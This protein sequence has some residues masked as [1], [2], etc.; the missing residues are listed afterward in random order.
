MKVNEVA[1][2]LLAKSNNRKSV[3]NSHSARQSLGT[4]GVAVG[5]ACL[6]SLG[7][8][9]CSDS[10][11][12][13]TGPKYNNIVPFE[14]AT[15]SADNSIF[16]EMPSEGD[17]Y[18]LKCRDNNPEIQH[19]LMSDNNRDTLVCTFCSFGED[20]LP[21][22]VDSVVALKDICPIVTSDTIIDSND[23]I[24]DWLVV[25]KPSDDMFKVVLKANGTNNDRSAVMVLQS[26]KA[27]GL[28]K[29]YIEFSQPA[30]GK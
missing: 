22:S 26:Q 28:D 12:G 17:T 11:D 21:A 18:I 7:L 19:F 6:S 13:D 5:L 14:W 1:N 15:D 10:S 4:F 3:T 8:S 2:E 16:F 24:F 23:K 27:A 29:M 25:S 9:S 20:G 30:K